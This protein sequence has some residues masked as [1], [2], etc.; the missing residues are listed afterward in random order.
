[1]RFALPQAVKASLAWLL[2]LPAGATL[3]LALDCDG[4]DLLTTLAL[5]TDTVFDSTDVAARDAVRSGATQGLQVRG[6]PPLHSCL[7]VLSLRNGS[8]PTTA[9]RACHGI[10]T[11]AALMSV[12]P[13]RAS[14]LA[15]AS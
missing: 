13:T 3:V 8:P 6:L 1:L 9:R 14:A 12:Q 15:F 4:N 7:G 10:E 2:A 5:A 11:I